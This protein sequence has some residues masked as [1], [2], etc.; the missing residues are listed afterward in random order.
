MGQLDK[1]VAIITGSA[2]GIGAATARLFASEGAK[3]VLADIRGTLAEER[4]EE[5]RSKGGIAIAVQVDVTDSSQ[6]RRMVERTITEFAGLHILYSHAGVASTGSVHDLSE[7]EWNHVLSVNLTGAFLCAKYAVPEIKRSGGGAIIT[8]AATTGLVAE[9]N[10]A[11]YCATKG[12]LI[13][14]SKQM[15]L[16]YARDGIRVNCICPG[17]ID[18]PFNDPF[19]ESPEAHAKTV[20]AVVP[21][22]RQGTV[23]EVARAALYLASD[24][25]Q[26]V[27]GLALVIDGGL[28]IQ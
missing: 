7:E 22:G 8:T 25:S 17:W 5:I 24:Q 20:D 27:T 18:T 9:K 19:I 28:T 3:V 16:D 11:A 6:V 4:A 23:D 10:I 12:G 14:L 2:S 15:A 26:Y 21:I 1:K 13:M